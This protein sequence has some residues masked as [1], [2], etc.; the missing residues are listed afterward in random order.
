MV[1]VSGFLPIVGSAFVDWLQLFV[2]PLKN[3]DMLWIIVPIWGVWLFSEFF[4]EKKGTSFGNA[5]SNGATML[6]VGVDWTRYVIRQLSAGNLELGVKSVTLIV[7]AAAIILYGLTII[8]LGIKA[9][10]L[11]RMIGRVRE[12]TYFMVV[13][14]PVIYGVENLSLRTAAVILAF[15]P[16]F[17]IIIEIIDRMLPTPRTF[18]AEEER[19]LEAGFGKGTGSAG[20]GGLQTPALPGSDFGQDVFGTGQQQGRQGLGGFPNYNFPQQN[21]FGEKGLSKTQQQKPRKLF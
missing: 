15:F 18:E 5:V 11:V 8:V 6:F 1:D 14:S 21:L 3:L 19:G 10:R 16:V 17:Y 13:F 9:N 2:A 4:Q 12:T 20:L 7:V